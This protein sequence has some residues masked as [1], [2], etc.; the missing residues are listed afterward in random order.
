MNGR[1]GQYILFG[2]AKWNDDAH[3]KQMK[4]LRAAGNERIRFKSYGI[5]ANGYSFVLLMSIYFMTTP[6]A[7]FL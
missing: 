1:V 2:K 3:R 6:C 7:T 4:R 5:I